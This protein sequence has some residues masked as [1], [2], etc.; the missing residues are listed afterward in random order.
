MRKFKILLI[1]L[2]I[3]I[4]FNFKSSSH[5][6]SKSRELEAINEAFLELITELFLDQ[7]IYFEIISCQNISHRSQDV[8]D[9]LMRGEF[10]SNIV[11]ENRTIL[12]TSAIIFCD[13]EDKIKSFLQQHFLYS[14]EQ[15]QKYRF[16]FFV[17]K[18][19][20]LSKLKARK[21]N[22]ELG[23]AEWYSYFLIKFKG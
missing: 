10:M 4:F 15:A 17:D 6:L 21:L 23:A 1:F 18:P 22:S 9:G 19:I 20:D 2:T 5:H 14:S 7:Q 16:L 11:H 3:L 13:S 8:L 12:I